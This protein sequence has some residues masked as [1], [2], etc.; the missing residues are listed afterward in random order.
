VKGGVRVPRSKGTRGRTQRYKGGSKR[1][2]H[3]QKHMA[4]YTRRET[5]IA[6]LYKRNA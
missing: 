5:E 2:K 3:I 4:E 6:S 1:R